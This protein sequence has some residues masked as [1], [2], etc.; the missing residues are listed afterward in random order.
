MPQ[1]LVRNVEK[2]VVRRLKERARRRGRSLQ[3]EVKDI[4]V[5]AASAPQLDMQAARRL[6]QRIRRRFR[7]GRAPDSVDLIREDRER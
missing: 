6:T 5:R 1:I 3:S 7:P 4:L 2:T